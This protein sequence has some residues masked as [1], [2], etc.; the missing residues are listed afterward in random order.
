MGDIM[1][2]MS[3]SSDDLPG[4]F[5]DRARIAAWQDFLAAAYAP[6]QISGLHGRPFSQA[7]CGR[8]FDDNP[9]PVD[10]L[11]FSGSMSRMSWTTRGQ[12][13]PRATHFVLVFNRLPTPL[14]L[15][16]LGREVRLDSG[17]VAIASCTEPGELCY[18]DP[19]DFLAVAIDQARLRDL[20]GRVEDLVA[21]PLPNDPALQH[22]RRYLEILPIQ[23]DAEQGRDL[24]A[25]IATTLTDL[26]ALALGAGRDAAATAKTRG[27]RSARQHEILREIGARFTDPDFSAQ[28]LARQMSVTDR[29]VQD[30]LHECGSS[31]GERVLELR[32]Q[33]ARAMVE[34][35]RYDRLRI[36][37]IANASGFNTIPYFNR[38]FRRRF[39][40]TPTQFRGRR[41]S[42]SN[43][44]SPFDA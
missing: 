43:G 44:G 15:N 20:V 13:T 21:R 19:H 23:H 33:R 9:A 37:E 27:L 25:H 34:D 36:G 16:Q 26:V 38:S 4:G 6:H 12:S 29:Y 24:F 5:D 28:D 3:F 18:V 32:L 41:P 22:L 8:R 42:P 30:L 7:L 17:T 2:S 35:C 39:G 31:F 14:A 11:R 10:V 1:R 40:A